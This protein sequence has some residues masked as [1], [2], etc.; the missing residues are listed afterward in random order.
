[1]SLHGALASI[2]RRRELPEPTK[3]KPVDHL[4]QIVKQHVTH[5]R[6]YQVGHICTSSTHGKR[7]NGMS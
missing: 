2:N 4:L 7:E 3:S 5:F 6:D 1:M